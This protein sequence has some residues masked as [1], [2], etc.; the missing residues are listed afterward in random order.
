MAK[1]VLGGNGSRQI[2]AD[3]STLNRHG[4]IA[5]ATGTGKTVSLQVLIE[6]LSLAG[7][8]V[9]VP[10]VKGD[11]TGIAAPGSQHA[12]VQERVDYIG[13]T[14]H[15]FAAMPTIFWD[16][17]GEK[18]HSLRTTISEMG[19]LLLANLLELNETQ[20]GVLYACFREADKHG[21]LMMDLDDLNAMM[22]WVADNSDELKADYGNI[23]SA[24]VGAI[25]RRLIIMEEQGLQE[26]I[27]EPAVQISDFMR[28]DS[29][30][31]GHVNVLQAASLIQH[32]P[33]LYSTLLLWLLSELYEDLPEVGDLDR[34]KLVIFL[35]EAHL[36]F[37]S[38]S[39]TLLEK[40]EQTVRLIR[41]KGVGV[42]FI[43]QSPLDIPNEVAG[44][45]GLKIQHALR[46][47]TAKDKKAVKAVAE[48]F[49]TNDAFDT[50]TV[51]PD[52]GVGEALISCLDDKARPQAVERTL[53]SPPMSKIGPIPNSELK[54]IVEQSPFGKMF[55]VRFDR[56]SAHEILQKR[57]ESKVPVPEKEKEKQ[58]P[59]TKTRSQGR[60]R[61][62][63]G[64][65]FIK[66]LT[67]S[68]GSQI[69]R[70]IVRGI[71]GSIF[72]GNK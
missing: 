20:T 53:M 61:Q 16:V 29:S 34:P 72:K 23:S 70:Q 37:N 1:L 66:S 5:G 41:S 4:L 68:V 10:D 38:A 36:V 28:V 7:V 19:P 12:K 14:N 55:D 31:H 13:L 30:G 11:L 71:L 60:S 24:S 59:K 2:V 69:G 39:K 27:G 43:T 56:E 49:R 18:G 51:L 64:E 50:F 21:W 3:S 57:A 67:R 62:S 33:R 17:K 9:F 8:P 44:Q 65:A 40:I 48:N 46:A 15:K 25:K 52:L 63:T 6:Q 42:V 47:F 35:D 45:L 58:A 32:S 26:F 54:Q 22:Q